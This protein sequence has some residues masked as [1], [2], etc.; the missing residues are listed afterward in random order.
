MNFFLSDNFKSLGNTWSSPFYLCLRNIKIKFNIH[1]NWISINDLITW[2]HATKAA[3][4]ALLSLFCHESWTEYDV[5]KCD[6]YVC[7]WLQIPI[8]LVAING[9]SLITYFLWDWFQDHSRD[10]QCLRYFDCKS[11]FKTA[12]HL[13]LHFHFAYGWI[14]GMYIASCMIWE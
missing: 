12:H 14:Q 11:H 3:G 4:L 7:T 9:V 8:P 13:D 10:F 5:F 6:L 1:V 2:W